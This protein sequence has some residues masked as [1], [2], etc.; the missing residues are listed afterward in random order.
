MRALTS[1]ECLKERKIIAI[2]RGVNPDQILRLG[3]ALLEGGIRMMELTYD[4]QAPET[5]PETAAAIG[6]EPG[7]F[8][9]WSDRFSVPLVII[10]REAKKLSPEVYVVRS[11]E[12][13]GMEL[14]VAHLAE[15]GCRKIG[16]IIHGR[17]GTGNAD[18]R[19][20]SIRK[21]LRK[22]ALPCDDSLIRFGNDGDYLEIIGK[23][24]RKNPD[25][26]FCPGGSG[27]ILCAYALSMFGRKI[28]EDISLIASEQTFF[29]RYGTPP[30]TTITPDYPGL[31]SAVADVI[32][33]RIEGRRAPRQTVLPYLLIP[34]DSVRGA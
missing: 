24:L 1:L 16:C 32:E 28:P 25:A 12:A 18:V 5:W 11:D 14:A 33:A 8:A 6:A 3:N 7:D 13:Q 19:C 15:H 17:P 9:S 30:Q 4:Q 26:L 29:S 21:A 34:R 10:D 31:A 20:D 2:V 23:M 22:H 27:G